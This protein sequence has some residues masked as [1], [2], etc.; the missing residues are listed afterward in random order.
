MMVPEIERQVEAV[1]GWR[2]SAMWCWC[3]AANDLSTTIESELNVV[4]REREDVAGER[5]GLCGMFLMSLP[6]SLPTSS[7]PSQTSSSEER[8][9][10]SDVSK[11]QHIATISSKICPKCNVTY[12]KNEYN[13]AK[14]SKMT[15]LL[16]HFYLKKW[17]RSQL[18]DPR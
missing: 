10:S 9:C 16:C 12:P 17:N 18:K 8:S 6:I 3:Q 13:I 1:S 2:L 4:M 14:H 5:L 11:E 7:L 15:L